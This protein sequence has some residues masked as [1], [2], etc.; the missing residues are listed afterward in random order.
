MSTSQVT[1]V[2]IPAAA[3][4]CAV[5]GLSRTVAMG[6]GG[7]R[8]VT[9][10]SG[11]RAQHRQPRPVAGA[12]QHDVPRAQVAPRVE[13]VTRV[14]ER[15]HEPLGDQGAGREPA[16]PQLVDEQAGHPLLEVPLVGQDPHLRHGAPSSWPRV[17]GGLEVNSACRA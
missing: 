15:L 12:G 17:R 2:A 7:V 5:R 4:T 14:P 9:P 13:Q 10:G 6:S 8:T 3:S 11:R 1:G 16:R